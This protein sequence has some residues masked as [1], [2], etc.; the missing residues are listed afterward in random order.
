MSTGQTNTQIA[1]SIQAL[2]SRLLDLTTSAWETFK[3][4]EQ[5]VQEVAKD[6]FTQEMKAQAAMA[7]LL[8]VLL[9]S[10]D[11]VAASAFAQALAAQSAE[12]LRQSFMAALV[13]QSAIAFVKIIDPSEAMADE[14][15]QEDTQADLLHLYNIRATQYGCFALGKA[16]KVESSEPLFTLAGI[17]LSEALDC[18]QDIVVIMEGMKT[19]MDSLETL[20]DEPLL[21]QTIGEILAGLQ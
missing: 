14:D 7:E 12:T 18:P 21:K 8:L 9:H 10:C 19:V 11:R 15:E 13:G 20:R 2:S 16:A 5:I 1:K 4:K 6:P 17:R 3:E